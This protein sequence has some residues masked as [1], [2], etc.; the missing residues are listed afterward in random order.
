MT[1]HAVSVLAAVLSMLSL[2]SAAVCP[3]ATDL[4]SSTDTTG[5][6][7]HCSHDNA[8]RGGEQLDNSI[9]EK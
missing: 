3:S 7:F 5:A 2:A 9:G 8:Q 6:T 1:R 4:Q